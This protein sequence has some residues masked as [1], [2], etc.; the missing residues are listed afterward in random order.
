MNLVFLAFYSD[1]CIGVFSTI[2]KGIKAIDDRYETLKRIGGNGRQHL[3]WHRARGQ[4]G[5]EFANAR[6]VIN[7][8]PFGANWCYVRGAKVDEVPL[9]RINP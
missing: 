3:S 2:E 9:T 5:M 1:A 6:E 4:D 7:G 8:R